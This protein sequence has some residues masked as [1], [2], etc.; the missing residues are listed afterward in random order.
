VHFGPDCLSAKRALL[1]DFH[2]VFESNYTKLQLVCE[3]S[4]CTL[5]S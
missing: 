1:V 5:H 3:K 2:H 4:F